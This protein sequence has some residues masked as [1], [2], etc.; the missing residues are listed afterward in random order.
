MPTHKYNPLLK[1]P[2][3]NGPESLAAMMPYITGASAV[4]GVVSTASS[5]SAQ[6]KAQQ[7]QDR[8]NQVE[9]HKARLQA[10]REA[11]IRAAQVAQL[12]TN[13]GMGAGSSAPAGA[14]SS[15]GSQL[16][17]N[18]A[19]ANTRQELGLQASKANQAALNASGMASGFQTIFGLARGATD[20][21]KFWK[22]DGIKDYS[23]NM[24]KA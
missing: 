13:Q 24:N 1:H 15:I 4:A 16:G 11:R 23:S 18:M 19:Y 5:I 9:A 12:G 10:V 21:Q 6:K 20:W 17:A 8:L 22:P 3:Y 7:A 2:G 14:T